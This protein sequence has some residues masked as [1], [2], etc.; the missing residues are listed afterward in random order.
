MKQNAH[1]AFC[2]AAYG[3]FQRPIGIPLEAAEHAVIWLLI[4]FSVPP[5]SVTAAR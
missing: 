1:G 5:V 2:W 4:L 3:L